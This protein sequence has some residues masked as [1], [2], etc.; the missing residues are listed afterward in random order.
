VRALE[1]S[2]RAERLKEVERIA[3][4]HSRNAD[5]TARRLALLA[6]WWRD[7]LFVRAG[8]EELVVNRDQL[9]A[10]RPRA[11]ALTIG[12]IGVALRAVDQTELYLSENVQPR[13]ALESLALTLP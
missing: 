13:L 7:L 10:L 4:E 12:Q 2:S 9:A 5:A 3:G 11:A 6:S 1:A 8:C